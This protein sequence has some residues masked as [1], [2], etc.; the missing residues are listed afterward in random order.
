LAALIVHLL[1][2]VVAHLLEPAVPHLLAPVVAHLLEP[3]LFVYHNSRSMVDYVMIVIKPAICNRR[4]LLF[5][6]S[7]L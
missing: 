7:M 4:R 6:Q 5:S 1:E 3:A 2:P